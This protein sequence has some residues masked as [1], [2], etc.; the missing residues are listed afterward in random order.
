MPPTKRVAAVVNIQL[1]AA[2][3]NMGKA[4]QA[5]GPHGINLAEVVRAYNAA[6]ANQRG[7]IVPAVITIYDDPSFSLVT[8][9]PWLGPQGWG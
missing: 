8:A 3:A 6:T 9:R 7:E 1:E 2:E 4:G 5:L